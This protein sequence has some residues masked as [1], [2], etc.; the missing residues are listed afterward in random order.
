MLGL[1][2]EPLDGLAVGL[3][4]ELAGQLEDAGGAR[5][6]HADAP[7]PSVNLGVA[8]LGGALGSDGQLLLLPV[9]RSGSDCQAGVEC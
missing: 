8:V 7:P 2:E 4:A 6:R 1:L 5:G 9:V 3:V